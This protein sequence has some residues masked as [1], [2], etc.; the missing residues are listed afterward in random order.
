MLIICVSIHNSL[1]IFPY[2]ITMILMARVIH[3]SKTANSS[4]VVAGH[5]LG[6]RVGGKA[7]GLRTLY[8]CLD[9]GLFSGILTDMSRDSRW[10]DATMF[11]ISIPNTCTLSEGHYRSYLNT[12]E[13]ARAFERDLASVPD[14]MMQIPISDRHTLSAMRKFLADSPSGP[15]VARSSASC[16]DSAAVPFAG[17]FTSVFEV[18]NG[19]FPLRERM[20]W[21]N[22]AMRQVYASMFS[23]KVIQKMHAFRMDPMDHFLAVVLQNAI[24]DSHTVKVGNKKHNF[25][26]PIMTGMLGSKS[27]GLPRPKGIERQDAF[28]KLGFGMGTLTVGDDSD[29]PVPVTI[30]F[31][32]KGA[33]TDMVLAGSSSEGR[34]DPS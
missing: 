6:D 2:I 3:E 15:Y 8:N 25:H 14:V 9:E 34:Y 23:S 7:A 11:R 16:E 22:L 27:A 21:L 29:S 4:V 20:E 28:A 13:I 17:H 31:P 24:G 5:R 12:P 19:H 1:Y 32:K 30:L 33:L 26:L 18:N 10:K